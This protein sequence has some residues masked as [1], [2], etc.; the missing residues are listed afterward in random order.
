[1]F[2]MTIMKG[3]LTENPVLRK[4]IKGS[5]ESLWSSFRLA[6]NRER[7][8]DSNGQS[9]ADF[10]DCIVF[11]KRA[12]FLAKY[13]QKGTVLLVSGRLEM[14]TYTNQ[15][16]IK[17]PTVRLFVKTLEFCYGWKSS[18][19]ETAPERQHTHVQD[20]P[21]DDKEYTGEFVQDE[22]YDMPVL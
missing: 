17:I 19:E 5:Q 22:E 7:D 6:V 15:D 20:Y 16:N 21:I 12:E 11:G 18:S 9:P 13:G 14:G 1:M 8:R 4:K 2:N 10:F 3:R